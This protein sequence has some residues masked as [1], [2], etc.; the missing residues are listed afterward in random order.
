MRDVAE[1][2]RAHDIFWSQVT[3]ATPFVFADRDRKLARA[4]L[5]VLCWVLR[6]DHCDGFPRTLADLEAGLA[7]KGYRLAPLDAGARRRG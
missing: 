3:G 5:D 1:V 7:K 4:V 6:H 2:Q